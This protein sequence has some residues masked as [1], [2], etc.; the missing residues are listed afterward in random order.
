[1]LKQ[2]I[3]NMNKQIYNQKCEYNRIYKNYIN[4]INKDKKTLD[5]KLKGENPVERYNKLLE[6]TNNN[7]NNNNNTTT[8][9]TT[10]NATN[11]TIVSKHK[12]RLQSALLTNTE[13]P[14][15]LS[16]PLT[17][18]PYTATTSDD[19]VVNKEIAAN[20]VDSLN[21]V[22]VG[23]DGVYI[24]DDIDESLEKEGG[25]GQAGH[26]SYNEGSSPSEDS[27]EVILS[28][29]NVLEEEDHR[30]DHYTSSADPASPIAPAAA[31]AAASSSSSSSIPLTYP[32]PSYASTTFD[33][34]HTTSIAYAL[35]NNTTDIRGEYS[36]VLEGFID[37]TESECKSE[38]YL[39]SEDCIP[40]LSTE[41]EVRSV[42]ENI[43]DRCISAYD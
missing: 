1:M 2:Q 14:L 36:A 43:C 40:Y 26:L 25:E 6:L 5:S 21:A 10:S 23:V 35:D 9:T 34:I 28:P 22:G 39:A 16:D 38:S 18:Q 15:Q 3:N 32:H 12:K 7:N 11:N 33:S 24:N 4:I 37:E 41:E 27:D 30:P 31:V 19:I 20:D 29:E 17:K 8:N 13:S 42:I